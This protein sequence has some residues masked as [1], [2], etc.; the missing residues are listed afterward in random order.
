MLA[1]GAPNSTSLSNEARVDKTDIGT[2]KLLWLKGKE[3]PPLCRHKKR[4][5]VESW[6]ITALTCLDAEYP[7]IFFVKEGASNA[8][9]FT[10]FMINDCLPFLRAGDIVLGDNAVFHFSGWNTDIIRY[11]LEEMGASYVALPAYCPEY[12]PVERV[13]SYLKKR[14]RHRYTN[15]GDNL[16]LAIHTILAEIT[17]PK[18]VGW[19][20][21][22]GWLN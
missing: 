1:S 2:L 7:L 11:S 14:L 9:E 8:N 22:S 21:K 15:Q 5:V 4:E 3:K 16:L 19:Y 10:K 20:K 18:M 13:W 12:A 17:L 6:T